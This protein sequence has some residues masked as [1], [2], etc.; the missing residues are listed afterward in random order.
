MDTT[1]LKIKNPKRRINNMKRL[2]SLALLLISFL[3]L[4]SSANS[5][6]SKTYTVV[7]KTGMVI[8]SVFVAPTGSGSWGDNISTLDKLSNKEGFQYAFDVDQKNCAYDIKFKGEDGK[9]YTL[10]NINLC[11]NAV[12]TLTKPGDSN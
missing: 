12:V 7:N 5:Q 8:T 11:N 3:I 10:K 4:S 1:D 9:E 2:L 6:L